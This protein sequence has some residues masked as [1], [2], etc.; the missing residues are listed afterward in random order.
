MKLSKK[1][2]EAQ[3]VAITTDPSTYIDPGVYESIVKQDESSRSRLRAVQEQY[4]RSAQL[5]PENVAAIVHPS[6]DPRVVSLLRE[7]LGA[8]DDES[9]K[10]DPKALEAKRNITGHWLE[11]LK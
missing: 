3:D 4:A 7:Q 2:E 9:V 8:F 1:R 5:T 10:G 6:P 11:L